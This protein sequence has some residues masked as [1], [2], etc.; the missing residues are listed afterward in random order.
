[1]T[2]PQR[3]VA[4]IPRKIRKPEKKAVEENKSRGRLSRRDHGLARTGYFSHQ[5][6]R[7]GSGR[8]LKKQRSQK[9]LHYFCAD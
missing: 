1:M 2:P 9:A 3:V 6:E 4:W 7:K 5:T 8:S